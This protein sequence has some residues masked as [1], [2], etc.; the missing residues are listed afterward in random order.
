MNQKS[1]AQR[2]KHLPLGGIRFFEVLDSTN[3]EAADWAQEEAPDLS[4]VVADE[5]TQGRGRSGRQW[6]TYRGSALAFTLILRPT[7]FERQA[8]AV[9]PRMT[10]LGALA[11]C[12]ALQVNYS[13]PAQIKWPNDVLLHQ[14]KCCGILT[15]AA[16]EGKRLTAIF[17]G[18]GIN[19]ATQSVPPPQDLNFPATSL[20]GELHRPVDRLA[21]LE[22][23]LGEILHW[24]QRLATREFL[25]TWETN[26]AF[27]NEEIRVT[28][29]AGVVL[30][31]V[32]L[33]LGPHGALR[34]LTSKSE[35]I[36]LH[37]GEIAALW[38]KN[39]SPPVDSS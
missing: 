33:G 9:L 25:Q 26:L 12:R 36:T 11:V 19:V 38:G 39:T 30:E 14:R 28:S 4:L 37:H 16:W 21:L 1:L 23:V 8:T 7:P 10:G 13:L 20:E 24:R 32:L 3:R 34:L 35:E 5:Q 15:E 17:L 6:F 22:S 29:T 27:R 18:I 2:L 31:G